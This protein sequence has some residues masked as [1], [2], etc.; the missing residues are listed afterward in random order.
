VQPHP[1]ALTIPHCCEQVTPEAEQPMPNTGGVLTG[2]TMTVKLADWDTTQPAG[3]G[4]S[5][6]TVAVTVQVD[7]PRI[8][9]GSK[10]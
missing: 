6:D 7:S 5:E 9:A 2:E 10:G 8:P 1:G 4:W 3:R